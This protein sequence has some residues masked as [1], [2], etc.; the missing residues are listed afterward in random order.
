MTSRD[1]C[2]TISLLTNVSRHC[3]VLSTVS[4]MDAI[5]SRE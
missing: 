5:V 3:T 4:V 2:I 1:G